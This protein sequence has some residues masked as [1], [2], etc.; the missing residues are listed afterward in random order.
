F[1]YKNFT[2]TLHQQ[3]VQDFTSDD[4]FDC[5][6]YDAFAPNAQ[7]DMWSDDIFVDMHDLLHVDGFLVTYCAKG[8]FKRSL[9][10]AGFEVNSLPGPPGKREM[11]RAVRKP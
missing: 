10:K 2:L 4:K 11:V 9:A 5:I 1:Q 6:Y 7:I 8:S 3:K